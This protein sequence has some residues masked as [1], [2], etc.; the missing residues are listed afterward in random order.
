MFKI[1][2]N[3]STS[4]PGFN[5][6]KAES[7]DVDLI[8]SFIRQLAEYEKMLPDVVADNKTLADY[9]FCEHPFAH[10]V[11]GEYNKQ[12]VAFALFFTNFSTFLGRPGIYLEDLF[13]IP[14]FRGKGFGKAILAF[15]AKLTADNQFGRLEWCVLDWNEPAINFYKNLGATPMDEWKIFRLTGPSLMNMSSQL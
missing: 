8:L 1:P 2:E 14:E 6:R 10:V 4:I 5:I 15:L 9:L 12:A 3:T 7:Q 13:V 11:I